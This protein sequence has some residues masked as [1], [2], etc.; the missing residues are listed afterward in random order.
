MVNIGAFLGKTIVK[1][2]CEAM[3][4]TGLIWINYF[5]ATMTL[6]GLIVVFIW[7]KS[8]QAQGEGKNN[9]RNI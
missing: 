7:F 5:S 3:E 2:L 6:L 4:N 9:Q 8:R 1:P